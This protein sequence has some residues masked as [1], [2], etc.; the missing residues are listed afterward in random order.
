MAHFAKVQNGRVTQ[1]VV[2][3]DSDCAGGEFPESEAAGQAFLASIGL[4][5]E[6]KQCSYNENFRGIY[7]SAGC[8]YDP[9]NDE[10]TSEPFSIGACEL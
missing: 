1:V 10:F 3:A 6:W 5:G 2:V 4:D 9:I 8:K 7:P